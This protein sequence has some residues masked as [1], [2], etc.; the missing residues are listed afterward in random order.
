M[1][2]SI[3]LER[4]GG[5][6][7][8]EAFRC[9]LGSQGKV[10]DDSVREERWQ[11]DATQPTNRG[12]LGPRRGRPGRPMPILAFRS[13]VGSWTPRTLLGLRQLGPSLD[14]GNK[15]RDDPCVYVAN[16]PNVF[17]SFFIRII[18]TLL[19]HQLTAAVILF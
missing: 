17:I 6:E 10:G 11:R 14:F 12:N 13:A 3:K 16:V 5:Q 1:D 2:R 19:I 8:G 15:E 7:G 9:K 18:I 4:G